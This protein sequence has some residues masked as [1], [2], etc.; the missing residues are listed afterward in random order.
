MCKR[1]QHFNF[2]SITTFTH[3]LIMCGYEWNHWKCLLVFLC[4]CISRPKCAV[5]QHLAN[6]LVF[7]F[8]KYY[9]THTTPLSLHSRLKMLKGVI[10]DNRILLVKANKKCTNHLWKGIRTKS[11]RSIEDL[12][13]ITDWTSCVKSYVKY[14]S[15]DIWKHFNELAALKHSSCQVQF[16][17]NKLIDDKPLCAALFLIYYK[18][19]LLKRSV[20]P[21]VGYLKCSVCK[22]EALF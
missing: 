19:T 1:S 20:Q 12:L 8:F 17:N 21:S 4:I 11:G 5:L 9:N 3:L 15:R 18:P 22:W 2:L 10:S 13:H 14:I 16:S 7:L 6:F